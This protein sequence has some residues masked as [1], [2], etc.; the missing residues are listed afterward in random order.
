[1]GR[2]VSCVAVVLAVLSW[3]SARN[4]RAE[5]ITF[6]FS[7][8]L[9]EFLVDDHGLDLQVGDPFYGTVKYDDAVAPFLEISPDWW[10]T[11]CVRPLRLGCRLMFR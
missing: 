10:A 7:G 6:E 3:G 4:A 9:T 8:V 11:R 2:T 1:M 5:L